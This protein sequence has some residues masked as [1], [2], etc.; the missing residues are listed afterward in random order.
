MTLN[1]L[2]DWNEEIDE[3]SPCVWR[4]TLTHNLGPRLERVGENLEEIRGELRKWATETQHQIN[5][6]IE[7]KT[8]KN[9]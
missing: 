4:V 9:H 6:K 2:E 8:H 7:E 5:K 1:E 3:I